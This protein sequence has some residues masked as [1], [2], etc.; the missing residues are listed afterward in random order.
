M[1]STGDMTA[2]ADAEEAAAALLAGIQG[3]AL[4][5]VATGSPTY[6]RAALDTG[7]EALRATAAP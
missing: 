3:G 5:L 2:D 6:M 7:L 1:Q 4:M